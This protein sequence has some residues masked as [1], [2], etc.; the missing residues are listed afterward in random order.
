MTFP[1]SLDQLDDAPGFQVLDPEVGGAQP[2][3]K[4]PTVRE[5]VLDIINI[6]N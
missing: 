4:A 1:H 2:D 6:D 5:V 3:S